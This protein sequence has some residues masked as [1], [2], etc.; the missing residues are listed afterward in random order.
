[1]NSH[2]KP[3]TNVPKQEDASSNAGFFLED[4]TGDGQFDMNAEKYRSEQIKLANRVEDLTSVTFFETKGKFSDYD[5]NLCRDNDPKRFTGVA[6][7]VPG[8]PM[9]WVKVNGIAELKYR[10]VASDRFGSTLLDADKL[11]HLQVRAT[12]MSTDCYV[13]WA[14]TDCDMY[15]KVDPHKKFN[16]ALGRNT[17]TSEDL[18]YEYKPQV[19]IPISNLTVC[20]P[21][22]FNE[23][24]KN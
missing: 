14:F 24:R 5:Y 13:I 19:F 11:Q 1:M 10:R 12:Y 20:S 4:D 9:Y 7:T 6:S 17:Q 22:M 16:T 2:S 15:W 23:W 21:D 3:G 8:I 18:P